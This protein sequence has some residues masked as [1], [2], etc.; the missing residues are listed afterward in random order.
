MGFF[1]AR[2]RAELGT[3]VQTEVEGK[4]GDSVRDDF[5]PRQ[6][7]REDGAAGDLGS[8][9]QRV[10]K[11]ALQGIDDLLA[12]L[13]MRRENLLSETARVQREIIEYAKLSQSAVQSTQTINQRLSSLKKVPNASV[14]SELHVKDISNEERRASEGEV[15][16]QHGDRTSS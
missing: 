3:S 8:L 11:T 15:F 9:M 13:R 12:E 14:T 1:T 16:T 6:W 5:A 10:A 2:E 4:G 7:P